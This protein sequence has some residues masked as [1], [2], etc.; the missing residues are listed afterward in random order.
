M[1]NAGLD[2]AQAGIKIAGRKIQIH[3][4]DWWWSWNSNT[5]A[6]WCEELTHLKRDWCWERLKAGGEGNDRGWDGWMSSPTQWTWVWINSGSWWW[7][8]RPGVLRFMGSQRVGHDWSDLAAAAEIHCKEIQPVHPKGSQSWIF[9]GRT[10]AEAEAPKL[11]PPTAKNWLIGKD[12]YAAKDWR[13][14]EKETTE[15]EMVG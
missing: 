12:S 3:W 9:T 7:T 14:K 8:G 15:D 4:K 10:D 5:L 2:K 11:W 1:R 13:Q 6:T